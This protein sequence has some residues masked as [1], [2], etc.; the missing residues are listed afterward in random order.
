MRKLILAPFCL[1]LA[2]CNT[3]GPMVLTKTSVV[4]RP[5]FD[6]QEPRPA[7][8]NGV[9]WMIITRDNVGAKLDELE[10]TQGVVTLFALT[11]QGY[12]NLSINIAELR[13]YIAE[14][15]ASYLAVKKYYETP[16]ESKK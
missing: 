2:A 9:Q 11:P 10:K 5:K 7:S 4:D 16:V 1:L 15:N 8:Q 12:Q 14:K 3:T 13:R 6:A